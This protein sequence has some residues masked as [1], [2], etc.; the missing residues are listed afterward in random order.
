MVNFA[1]GIPHPNPQ[2]CAKF[3]ITRVCGGKCG[4]SALFTSANL[5]TEFA[6]T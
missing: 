4:D 2:T 3:R 6:H 5:K 1:Y